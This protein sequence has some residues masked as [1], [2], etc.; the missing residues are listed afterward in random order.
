MT[1][2]VDILPSAADRID[3]A[4]FPEATSG[5]AQWQRVVMNRAIDAHIASLRPNSLSAAEISGDGH[6]SKPWREYTSLN[7]PEFD[8]CEPVAGRGPFDVVICEQVL[9]HVVDPCAA[10]A[11]LRA[12]TVPGGHVI[13][14]TPFLIK[15]HGL[16]A[17]ALTP[18]RS[19]ARRAGLGVRAQ[20]RLGETPLGA[21]ERLE[22]DP[23]PLD[24]GPDPWIA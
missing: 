22:H 12:L 4:V 13:V 17:L 7:H 3:R 19:R 8:L 18:Q 16:P 21:C 6:A 5:A 20:S 23:R 11:N 14:S 2:V 9:E 24:R 10:A 15:V 1:R